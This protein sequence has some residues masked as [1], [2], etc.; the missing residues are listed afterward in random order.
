ML[1]EETQLSFKHKGSADSGCL[2]LTR[3]FSRLRLMQSVPSVPTTV[4]TPALMISDS[5]A[6][7]CE[8]TQQT[9]L[10]NRRVAG[11]EFCCFLEARPCTRRLATGPNRFSKTRFPPN[12]KGGYESFLYMKENSRLQFKL[13]M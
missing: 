13:A 9:D 5:G 3:R 10:M 7:G 4:V 8:H 2:T 6:S 11:R 1:R 12:D